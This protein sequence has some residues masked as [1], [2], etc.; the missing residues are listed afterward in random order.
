MYTRLQFSMCDRLVASVSNEDHRPPRSFPGRSQYEDSGF[1]MSRCKHSRDS[2]VSVV[3]YPL[4]HFL[5]TFFI[6][7]VGD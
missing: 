6:A 3:K 1:R 5:Q 4:F 2:I 7:L